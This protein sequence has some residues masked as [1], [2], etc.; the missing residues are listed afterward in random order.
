MRGVRR[1]LPLTLPLRKA[2]RPRN[3]KPSSKIHASTWASALAVAL[4][5]VGAALIIAGLVRTDEPGAGLRPL[6]RTAHLPLAPNE[7]PNRAKKAARE[8]SAQLAANLPPEIETPEPEIVTPL[9]EEADGEEQ[10][11]N[12]ETGRASWYDLASVTASGEVMD[13]SALTAAHRTL[14]LGTKVRVENLDNGR[15]VVV[16]INDRGPFAKNRIIDLSKEA[17]SRLDMIEDGVAL[18]AVTPVGSEVAINVKA[19]G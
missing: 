10:D 6:P 18:V 7:T 16:R 19:G 4:L 5:C 12:P 8:A 17:A 13:A 15:A 1:V 3:G 14:A 2:R 11:A 9:P